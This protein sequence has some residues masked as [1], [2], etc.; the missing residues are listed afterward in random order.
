MS[1]LYWNTT[2]FELKYLADFTQAKEHLA[3]SPIVYRTVDQMENH[4]TTMENLNKNFEQP[5][6]VEM[7]EK[8][9]CVDTL[10]S[11]IPS[12]TDAGQ[13]YLHQQCEEYL[14]MRETYEMEMGVPYRPVQL[15]QMRR[16]CANVH[17]NVKLRDEVM[18][19]S[20][21]AVEQVVLALV[22]NIDWVETPLCRTAD[23]MT[24]DDE[25][26]RFSVGGFDV[27]VWI[28][29]HAG[30]KIA[31]VL[32]FDYSMIENGNEEQGQ[33]EEV[34]EQ[35]FPNEELYEEMRE[36][37]REDGVSYGEE[38]SWRT[39][40]Y[41]EAYDSF[42]DAVRAE[43]EREALGEESERPLARAMFFKNIAEERGV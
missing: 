38:R 7:N 43:E 40:T 9:A 23:M 28:C 29:L 41:L 33:E 10:I 14:H 30:P 42:E 32:G 37:M 1:Q 16:C 4:L 3:A 24:V 8:K 19:N 22:N 15:H 27:T 6:I 2:A 35:G 39:T 12:L 36:M 21:Y 11:I 17:K 26:I 13:Q 5:E 25:T 20:W 31:D 18:P 34:E